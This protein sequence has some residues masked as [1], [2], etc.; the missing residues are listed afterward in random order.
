MN[1]MLRKATQVLA[2]LAL[3]ACSHKRQAP[4][5]VS[6]SS[7]AHDC[8]V[9]AVEQQLRARPMTAVMIAL[10]EP[11]AGDALAARQARVLQA[12]GNEFRLK[13]RYAAVAALAGELTHA[14]LQ[15]ARTLSDIRCV[16]LDGAGS[17][18]P[19]LPPTQGL[20]PSN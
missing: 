9:R 1:R 5:A 19:P 13:R 18:T 20:P 3:I 16:Q 2:A 10:H 4:S 12:L 8:D 14:G 15:R 17:G 11:G 6:P 7:F